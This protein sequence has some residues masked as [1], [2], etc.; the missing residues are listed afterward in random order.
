MGRITA[1]GENQFF[2]QNKAGFTLSLRNEAKNPKGIISNHLTL[3]TEKFTFKPLK[4]GRFIIKNNKLNKCLDTDGKPKESGIYKMFKCKAGDE[5]QSFRFIRPTTVKLAKGWINIIGP[6]YLCLKNTGKGNKLIQSTCSDSAEML[7]KFE[8][9]KGNIFTV[10]NKKDQSVIDLSGS[11]TFKGNGLVS[12]K[13]NNSKS[14]TWNVQ[15]AK[16]GHIILKSEASGR[17]LG[18]GKIK[19]GSSYRIW[20]CSKKNKSQQ[21]RLQY[22]RPAPPTKTKI[23]YRTKTGKIVNK[24]GGKLPIPK[25]IHIQSMHF[26]GKGVNSASKIGG[27]S[28]KNGGRSAKSGGRSAKNGGRSAKKGGSSAKKGGRSAKK[29]GSSA[30]KG[31]SSAKKGGQASRKGKNGKNSIRRGGKSSKN[32]KGNNSKTNN[33]VIPKGAHIQSINYQNAPEKRS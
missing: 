31:G 20:D 24:D 6:D 8:V 3:D 11:K 25:G 4:A 33:N 28:A 10:V 1:I 17:C 7:W 23:V 14:Q 18:G 30:K 32:N 13:R 9:V 26:Q 19:K 29:G 21:F 22:A 5:G 16:K 2:I 12:F 15:T 27:R